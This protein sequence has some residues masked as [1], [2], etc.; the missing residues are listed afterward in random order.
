MAEV[1]PIEVG[2]IKPGSY[3]IVDGVAC[4]V[5]SVETSKP[6]K[7]GHMKARIEAVGL[8]DEVKR[9]IVKPGHDVM[10]QPIIEKRSAQVLS[11]TGDT[12]NVM[13]MESFET[14]DIKIP[15]ELKSQVKE[16]IQVMY[17]TILNDRVMKQLR[18]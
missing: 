3:L 7:H 2:S 17:W 11:V 10:E 8:V 14:F 5:K 18:G 13:D 9:I 16:G 6:G 4:V 12:A 15:E 1:K